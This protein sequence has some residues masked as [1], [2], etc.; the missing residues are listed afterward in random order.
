MS[1]EHNALIGK[2]NTK[3]KKK[4]KKLKIHQAFMDLK[5]PKNFKQDCEKR[6]KL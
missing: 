1:Q 5:L 3:K 4:S 6:Q 2:L